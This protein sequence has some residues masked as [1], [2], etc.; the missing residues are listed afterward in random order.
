[1]PL[2]RPHVLP[3]GDDIDLDLAEFCRARSRS[4]PAEEL[5]ADAPW[6]AAST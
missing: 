5:R 6:S 4:R 3:K 1:M 2:R